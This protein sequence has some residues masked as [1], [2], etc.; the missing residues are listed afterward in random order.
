[1]PPDIP[2]PLESFEL[3]TVRFDRGLSEAA[4]LVFFVIGEVAFEPF[5]VAVPLEGEDVGCEPVEEEA[6]VADDHGA[7]G[8]VLE[9]T[10][11]R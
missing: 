11:E 10:F 7:T 6:V 5:N 4:L 2:L 3:D 1:M 9:G 8:E